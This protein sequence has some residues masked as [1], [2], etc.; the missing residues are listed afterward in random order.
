M[1]VALK[2]LSAER[3]EAEAAV[4]SG[5]RR[6]DLRL[7]AL[8]LTRLADAVRALSDLSHGD[9]GNG[10]RAVGD[11]DGAGAGEADDG[12][13]AADVCPPA[14]PASDAMAAEGEARLLLTAHRNSLFQQAMVLRERLGLEELTEQMA[15]AA[16]RG[17]E[18]DAAAAAAEAAEGAVQVDSHGKGENADGACGSAVA[19]DPSV[20]VSKGVSQES[21]D[22]TFGV[23]EESDADEEAEAREWRRVIAE[24]EA[25]EAAEAEEGEGEAASAAVVPQ[26]CE[27]ETGAASAAHQVEIDADDDARSNGVA[28]EPQ[29]AESQTDACADEDRDGRRNSG[30]LS[31]APCASPSFPNVSD[32]LSAARLDARLTVVASMITSPERQVRALVADALSRVLDAAAGRSAPAHAFA[33]LSSDCDVEAAEACSADVAETENGEQWRGSDGVEADASGAAGQAAFATEDAPDDAPD[34]EAA[35]PGCGDAVTTE[36]DTKAQIE[37]LE[38]ERAE[39]D[40]AIEAAVEQEDYDEA[41][42]KETALRTVEARLQSLRL[43]V[44]K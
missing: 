35:M 32:G 38:Q 39:L 42:R 41:D 21:S 40:S 11:G 43:D 3:A 37:R 17:T 19:D 6:R 10:A 27:S 25:A 18:S 7:H 15:L 13:C 9:G 44:S 14:T 2:V 24:M 23:E 36:A 1:R 26:D 12:D 16:S 22:V 30:S 20:A 31:E 4:A 28:P 34:G 5:E 29:H 33:T 8:L